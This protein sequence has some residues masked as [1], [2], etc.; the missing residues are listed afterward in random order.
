MLLRLTDETGRSDGVIAVVVGDRGVEALLSGTAEVPVQ[1]IEPK[2]QDSDADGGHSI[3]NFFLLRP[4][5]SNS[6]ITRAPTIWAD[7]RLKL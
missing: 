2:G 5:H 6:N 1:S 7:R 3:P 4:L